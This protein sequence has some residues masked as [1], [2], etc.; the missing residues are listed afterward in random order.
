M[1]KVS[2]VVPV[3][4]V[5]KYINRCIESIINQTYKNIEIIL[6]DDGSTDSSGEI[7]DKYS[8]KDSRIKVIHKQN[9]G[10][11]DARNSGIDIATGDYLLFVDS[12]DYIDINLIK[13]MQQYM[14]KNIDL[15]KFKMI[16]V[17]ETGK[18]LYKVGGP[19]FEELTGEN[20]FSKLV[21]EDNL[22]ECACIYLFK[23]DMIINKNF[24]FT[25][26]TE[27]EDFGL[28]PL[29]IISAKNIAST[30]YYGYYY[31]QSSNS[32]TRNSEYVRTLKKFNDSLFHYD[33]MLKFIKIHNISS[34]IQ[35]DIKT[36]YTNSIILKL[37]ELNK[38][39]RNMYIS[40]IKRRKM[41]RN[42]QPNNFK[43][44]IKKVILLINVNWYLKL[45]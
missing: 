15:I 8:E 18:E 10:L 43:Q 39:D 5:E 16:A 25:I 22:L 24:K 11:S 2:I 17:D 36:Y 12:D 26:S 37:K 14:D 32:I 40:E 33:N 30:N 42:I 31:V 3:Y 21:Y 41:I 27:H 35:R 23:K 20:A 45:K 13:N 4:N 34:K 38:Q 1:C 9:G 44:F 6:V 28:I 29:I 19:I 7:C